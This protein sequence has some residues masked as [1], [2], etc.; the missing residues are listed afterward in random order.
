MFFRSCQEQKNKIDYVHMKKIKSKKENKSG[1]SE[2]LQSSKKYF[3]V[4][5]IG[6]LLEGT[7]V[8]IEPDYIRKLTGKA[9][10]LKEI[11]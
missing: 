3:Q 9:A 6:D 1:M 11:K 4:P 2:L 5:N 8:S 10:R 7:I